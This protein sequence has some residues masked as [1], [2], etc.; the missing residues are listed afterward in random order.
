[1]KSAQPQWRTDLLSCPLNAGK[2]SSVTQLIVAMR[3]CATREA[4]LQWQQFHRKHWTGFES[5]ASKGWNRPWI[6][7]GKLTTG[8]GQMVMA[9]V[10]GSLQGYF[11]NVMNTYTSL[12]SGSTL[13]PT[14]RH[15]LHSI[16]RQSAWFQVGAVTVE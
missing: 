16:N 12:V 14:I 2:L 9:Q 3:Q 4:A 1:M 15:Q 10:A 7:S 5:M 11:G 6:K 8:Y 13:S